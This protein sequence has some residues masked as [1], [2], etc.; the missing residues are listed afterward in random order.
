MINRKASEC[1]QCRQNESQYRTIVERLQTA[2]RELATFDV[3]RN[4]SFPVLW[5]ACADALRE[6][7]TLREHMAAHAATHSG[8][9]TVRRE[10]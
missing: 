3:S 9:S 8:D 10:G 1:D 6:L 7:W 5:N 4:D 2:Q